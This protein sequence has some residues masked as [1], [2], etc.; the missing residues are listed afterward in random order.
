MWKGH[1]LPKFLEEPEDLSS[2][3]IKIC[4]KTRFFE[5]LHDVLKEFT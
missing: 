2:K 1:F 4:F 5:V 3:I